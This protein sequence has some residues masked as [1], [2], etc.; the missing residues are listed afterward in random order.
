MAINIGPG[1]FALVVLVD[2]YKGA[3]QFTT[4]ASVE[5]N[6][7]DKTQVWQNRAD[8]VVSFTVGADE[9][10]GL[11]TANLSN[12]ATPAKKLGISGHWSCQP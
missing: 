5:V 9:R 6:N 12:A 3:G 7:P 2:G 8:D 1:R 10:S 11:I 4:N